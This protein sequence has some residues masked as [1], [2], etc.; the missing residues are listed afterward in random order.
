MA[1]AR[2]RDAGLVDAGA[3]AEIYAFYV[4][5]TVVTFETDPP[6]PQQMAQRITAAVASHAWLVLEDDERVVGYACAGPFR[7]RAAYRWSCE[8]SVYLEHGRQRR[9]GGRAL[10]EAL[11][12]RLAERGYRTAAAAMALPNEDSLGL[13]R[14]IGFSPVGTYRSIG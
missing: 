8:V 13:H 1:G 10:Y 3:C 5:Q 7:D 11:L 6:T 12:A 9:G 2:V 14:A 4:T